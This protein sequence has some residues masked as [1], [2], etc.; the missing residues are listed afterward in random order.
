MKLSES[1][2]VIDGPNGV[3][4]TTVIEHLKELVDACHSPC[5]FT[6]EPTNSL[7][8]NFIRQH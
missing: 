6:K 7:L 3:G 8:G 5:I 2:F 1:L 4:K